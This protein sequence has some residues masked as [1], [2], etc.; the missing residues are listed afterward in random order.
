MAQH[1]PMSDLSSDLTP[2]VEG[3]LERHLATTKEW[4]PHRLVPWSRG[5]DFAEDEE[6]S[7]EP[8]S[9]S[10]AARV[11]LTVNLLTEDNLPYYSESLSD[12]R[13][14]GAWAEWT[15]RW[16]AEEGRHA[17]VIR[18]Y[19]T[20]SRAVDPVAL[21]RS[22]MQ[23]V[24]AGVIP[25]FGNAVPRA[26]VHVPARARDPR[27]APQHRRAPHRPRRPHDHASGR[28]RREPAPPL[29]SGSRQCRDRARSVRDGDRDGRRRPDLRDAGDRHHR[30]HRGSHASSRRR[31]CTTSRSTT[32]RSSSPSYSSAGDSQTSRVSAARQ[33]RPVTDC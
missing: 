29:L 20:V 5:R 12:G 13:H 26:R 4:F 31:A 25:H 8:G 15:R 16:T 17:I 28:G 30:L 9:C 19:L 18:D 2:V 23:Q 11:A 32:T 7:A 33:I 6:W 14:D 3:L 21:E 24:S 27:R 22:R 1:R 10:E